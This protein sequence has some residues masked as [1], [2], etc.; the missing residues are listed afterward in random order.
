VSKFAYQAGL[1]LYEQCRDYLVTEL[2]GKPPGTIMSS[3]EQCV[4]N[5]FHR[6]EMGLQ[7]T[8]LQAYLDYKLEDFFCNNHEGMETTPPVEIELWR[9]K[10]GDRRMRTVFVMHQ[11]PSSKIHIIANFIS[12]E[13]CAAI[14]NAATGWALTK[15]SD[16][17]G[18][19]K[20]DQIRDATIAR[21]D[22]PWDA[23]G[24]DDTVDQKL[25]Q[26]TGRRIFDYVNHTYPTLGITEAGQEPLM[27]IHY[28]GRGRDDPHPDQYYSHCDSDCTGKTVRQGQRVAT[29]IMYW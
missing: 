14:E 5:H 15:T 24:N 10:T 9:P 21:V 2:E 7:G 4:T 6:V 12:Q 26:Q 1:D 27:A 22:I 11:T 16:R 23:N 17:Q 18:G 3:I 8:Q 19:F 25:I 29:M 13:E 28:Q 20:P